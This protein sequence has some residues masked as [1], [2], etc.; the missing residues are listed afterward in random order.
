MIL[1]SN[2]NE[3]LGMAKKGVFTN[4]IDQL[5]NSSIVLESDPTDLGS[6]N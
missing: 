6:R 3:L 1:L 2:I 5:T 4:A